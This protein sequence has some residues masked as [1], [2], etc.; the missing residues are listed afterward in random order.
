MERV[1]SVVICIALGLVCAV[2][3]TACLWLV[4]CVLG[5]S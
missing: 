2:A 4:A 1:I 3:A 5:G